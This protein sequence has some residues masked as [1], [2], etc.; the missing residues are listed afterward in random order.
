LISGDLTNKERIILEE[1]T[2]FL[3]NLAGFV[4][5]EQMSAADMGIST[6]KLY[7]VL[8]N[9]VIDWHWLSYNHPDRFRF[10]GVGEI[11][12]IPHKFGA[13]GQITPSVEYKDVQLYYGLFPN[14]VRLFESRVYS[15]YGVRGIKSIG[16]QTY[17][18]FPT[19]I[20]YP[21]KRKSRV[22]PQEQHYWERL[23]KVYSALD[24]TSLDALASCRTETFGTHSLW[25]QFVLWKRYMGFAIDYLRQENGYSLQE[26][27]KNKL[28][29]YIDTARACIGQIF[30]KIDHVN[31]LDEHIIKAQQTSFSREF[32][33]LIP[34]RDELHSDISGKLAGFVECSH[35]LEALHDICREYQI[36]LGLD[37]KQKMPDFTVLE[38]RLD[39]IEKHT[40]VKSTLVNN[41]R[42]HS[43][44]LDIGSR[45]EIA[46]LIWEL[47]EGVF[48]YFEDKLGVPFERPSGHYKA[49]LEKYYPLP[50]EH[51]IRGN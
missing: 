38:N 34:C 27:L 41:G 39:Y 12:W 10:N 26:D 23:V 40:S 31:H 50:I 51:F 7:K 20:D 18:L 24:D 21:A 15:K 37:N 44:F 14:F 3:V 42:W 9:V 25:M 49:F 29:N 5:Q 1:R 16:N 4:I 46:N 17:I 2:A 22:E 19:Y 48:K 11:V 43:L 8:A 30:V 45:K 47:S 33:S 36:L 35:I 28:T 32:S 13:L 6:R